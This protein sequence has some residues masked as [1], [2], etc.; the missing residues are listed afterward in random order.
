MET[1]KCNICKIRAYIKCEQCSAP[2]Y[3]CSR[4]HLYSHKMKCH[5]AMSANHLK[6]TTSPQQQGYIAPQQP[7]PQSQQVDMRKLFEHLQSTKKDIITKM[8]ECKF[9]EA[10]ELIN[11]SL[12]LSRKFYQEDHP[13]NIELL[14]TL[15]EC[16]FNI[17]N[18]DQAK[19]NLESIISLTDFL[20]SPSTTSI[21]RH[22]ANM[23]L[24]AISLNLGDFG[25]AL[26]AYT[27]CEEELPSICREPEL[28]VKLASVYLNL[29]IC[30]I[31]LSNTN[32]AEKYLKKGLSQTEGI[33][34]N[35][36]IHKI[37]ADLYEN[38][39]VLYEQNFK[40]KESMVYYKKSLKLKFG[41]YGDN[42]DEVLELQY[43]ISSVY[44]SLKQYKEAEEILNSMTEVVLKD[45]I[46]FATQETIYRYASYFY[47]FGVVLI[48]M[49]KLNISRF[50]LLKAKD[51]LEGFLN[52]DDPLFTNIS[53][54]VKVCDRASRR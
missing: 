20:S 34:G 13:F 21:F 9:T 1:K 25:A 2:T 42:H 24:G 49:G 28:N 53:N 51:I 17:S 47:T 22:K 29:G 41:L 10:I 7:T 35:D 32:I 50:Y 38:L 8:S 39:G 19:S 33:L 30:Y 31:Y 16:Y 11:K 4:G 45:K 52:S 18:L 43:K 23:L 40:F 15:S 36:T 12:T 54:L 46:N 44:L 48:K 14:Y 6:K 26:K 27:Q 37:N 5:R 3:F